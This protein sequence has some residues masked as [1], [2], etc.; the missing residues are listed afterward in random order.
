MTNEASEPFATNEDPWAVAGETVDEVTYAQNRRP[1]RTYLS[2]TFPLP[3]IHSGDYGQP[4]R[5]IF[6]AFDSHQSMAKFNGTEWTVSE[7]P[8]GRRQLK[9]LVARDGD[10]IK[11]LWIERV[12]TRGASGEVKCTLHLQGKE[13]ERLVELLRNLKYIPIDGTASQRV[14]D[15][16]V[17][18]LLQNPSD[19]M[20]LY[21]RHP[22]KFRELIT[23]DESARDVIAIAHR[24]K[25]VSRFRRLLSDD[26]YFASELTELAGDRPEAVWQRFFEENPWIL[27]ISL[28]GQLLTSWSDDKLEQIVTGRSI[29]GVGKRTDALLHTA[30]RIKTMTFA[31]FK[32][33]RTKLLEKEYRSGCW[34]PSRELSGGVA[35]IQGTVHRCVQSV[36]ERLAS[37]APDGS[38]IPGDFTYLIQPR[39]FLVIGRLDELTGDAG[40]DHI[41]RIRSFELFRRNTNQPEIV[42]YDELLAR[43]EW[44]VETDPSELNIQR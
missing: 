36:G 8:Q 24:R 14:D 7:S 30:G 26:S 31:E 18:D 28:A 39:S 19:L 4:A 21:R 44:I 5:F 6:K 1:D 13:A 27:G 17:R 34:S 25:Q 16:L 22:E 12:P 35:Q 11:D 42:T 29:S 37:L 15:A 33:H 40:G 9:L 20:R 32:T 2:R 3:R 43:A 38:E 23:D 41:D 10:H